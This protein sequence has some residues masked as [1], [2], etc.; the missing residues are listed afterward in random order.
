LSYLS[1][2]PLGNNNQF[3]ENLSH[4]Q[5]FGFTLARPVRCSAQTLSLGTALPPKSH[6]LSL[7]PHVRHHGQCVPACR[8]AERGPLRLLAFPWQGGKAVEC[9]HKA[10]LIKRCPMFED[11]INLRGDDTTDETFGLVG[12]SPSP[13]SRWSV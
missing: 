9:R 5:G 2:H 10:S 3:H 12:S 4:S 1:S 6:R 8:V 13:R 7:P 11:V